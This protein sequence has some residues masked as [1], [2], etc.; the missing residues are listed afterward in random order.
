MLSDIH[1]RDQAMLDNDWLCWSFQNSSL[2]KVSSTSLLLVGI[3]HGPIIEILNLCL[4]L[5]GLFSPLIGNNSFLMSFRGDSLDSCLTISLCYLIAILRL[6]VVDIL[7]LRI[8][9]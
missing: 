1:V 4:E 3:S 6:G 7:S 2:I 8:C 5:I 9:C